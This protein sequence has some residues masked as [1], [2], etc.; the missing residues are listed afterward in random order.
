[1]RWARPS[2]RTRLILVV[3]TYCTAYILSALWEVARGRDFQLE[4]RV[5]GVAFALVPAAGTYIALTAKDERA[6][7]FAQAMKWLPPTSGLVALPFFWFYTSNLQAGIGSE[8]F[9]TAAQVIPVFLL[10]LTLDVR[11][12]KILESSDLSWT[13]LACLLGEGAALGASAFE[14]F[15]GREHFTVVAASLVALFV[16]LIM[17]IGADLDNR[18]EPADMN[19]DSGDVGSQAPSPTNEESTGQSNQDRVQRDTQETADT[20]P[21]TGRQ[22][23]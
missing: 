3:V 8:F 17:A 13:T 23:T 5:N 18:A 20:E 7:H 14:T 15:R 11:R 2:R 22:S 21:Q 16:A 6:R 10:A 12:S 1:M 4:E 9:S 19:E